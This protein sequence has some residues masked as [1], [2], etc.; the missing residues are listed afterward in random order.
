M[1]FY[2]YNF[3]KYFTYIILFILAIFIICY[4]FIFKQ[5][6]VKTFN[7]NKKKFSDSSTPIYREG[8][9][10]LKNK[11]KATSINSNNIAELMFNKVKGL[12]QEIG[13]KEGKQETI[14]ILKNTKRVCN[15]ECAKCMMKMIDNSKSLKTI[16][17]DNLLFNE[18][19]ENC[20]KCK[21]YTELSNTIQNMIDNL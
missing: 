4:S 9:E 17:I 1:K 21:K 10:M 12:V 18:D 19:D 3:L 13:G 20:I 5:S 15:L 14:N 16:D 6:L 7:F 11:D 2:S 8:F